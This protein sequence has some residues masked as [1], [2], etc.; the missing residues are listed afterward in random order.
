MG[1]GGGGGRACW[2]E[3]QMPPPCDMGHVGRCAL[4]PLTLRHP[5]LGGCRWL[6]LRLSAPPPPRSAIRGQ[7]SGAWPRRRRQS[8][9]TADVR[10][11]LPPAAC[12]HA[13]GVA[14][15]AVRQ[16]H[17]SK[18]RCGRAKLL[19]DSMPGT[20]S[21]LLVFKATGGGVGG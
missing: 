19:A 10:S 16:V 2:S 20:A 4:H 11:T 18:R 6:S 1:L 7:P 15:V 5:T 3:R 13:R 21:G 17:A 9:R 8:G 14:S 12:V